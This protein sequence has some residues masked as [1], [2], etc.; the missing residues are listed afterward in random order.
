MLPPGYNNNYQIVQGPGYVMILVEMIHDA[1]IIP[2]DG[3][4]HAPA[5]RAAVDGR[6]ARPL[7]R[8]HARR[9]DDE[10]QR[11]EWPSA[12]PARTCKL[13]E[14]FT[15]VGDDT[16]TLSSS[17]STIPSTW[18]QPWTA[19]LP[20]TK[21]DGPIFEHACHEG[22]YGIDEHARRRSSR[23][24]ESRRSSREED[25]EVSGRKYRCEPNWR[26]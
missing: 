26:L 16:I 6:F 22:N 18:T 3:R 20:L 19:E 25:V 24:E 12:A 21:I 11:Q 9:R 1:R 15:R 8:R 2:L 14:R 5:E 7:G 13:T 17:R 10:L 4:P 23:R